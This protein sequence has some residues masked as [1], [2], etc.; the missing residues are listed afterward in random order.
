MDCPCSNP[1]ISSAET[2]GRPGTAKD[3]TRWGGGVKRE[4]KEEEKK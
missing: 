4:K 3:L 2:G 1:W